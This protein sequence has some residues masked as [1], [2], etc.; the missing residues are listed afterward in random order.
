MGEEL[1]QLLVPEYILEH[2]EYEKLENLSGVIR[3][4]LLDKITPWLLHLSY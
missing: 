2:F 3:V 1:I 4:H